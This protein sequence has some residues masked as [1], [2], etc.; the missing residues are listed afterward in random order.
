MDGSKIL[1]GWQK[2]VNGFLPAH[3]KAPLSRD[4]LKVICVGKIRMPLVGALI[5]SGGEEE[6]IERDHGGDFGIPS[7]CGGWS[8]RKRR[9]LG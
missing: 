2:T 1:H 4:T 3:S 7:S 5:N 9:K 8:C 6:N